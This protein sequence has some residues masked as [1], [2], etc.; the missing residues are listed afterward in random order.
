MPA[1]GSSY[2]PEELH[3]VASYISRDILPLR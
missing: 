3:D 1:F 2:S